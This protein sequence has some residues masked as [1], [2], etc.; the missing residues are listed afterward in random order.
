M[1]QNFCARRN[2]C[3]IK[4]VRDMNYPFITYCT[5][6]RMLSF[7]FC[8][9]IY[10]YTHTHIYILQHHYKSLRAFKLPN[11]LARCSKMLNE[12]LQNHNLTFTSVK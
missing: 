12:Y 7:T 11:N 2:V 8:G 1:L 3:A 6:Q 9:M 10:I 5:L 4:Y